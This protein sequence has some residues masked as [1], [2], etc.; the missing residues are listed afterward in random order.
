MSY[1]VEYEAIALTNCVTIR[2]FD[3]EDFLDCETFDDVESKVLDYL[4]SEPFDDFEF[5]EIEKERVIFP[6]KFKEEW[7]R[8]K[9][10]SHDD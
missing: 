1:E 10:N 4:S 3:P 8:L 9:Q 5:K 2:E 6:D 7:L